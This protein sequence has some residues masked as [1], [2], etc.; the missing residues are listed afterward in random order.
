MTKRRR[1]AGELDG[2]YV[3]QS[4]LE[5]RAGITSRDLQA[6]KISK[7]EY[8]YSV[9][10]ILVFLFDQYKM[11]RKM[12]GGKPVGGVDDG[13]ADLVALDISKKKEE[14]LARQIK[15]QLALGDLIL[16]AEAQTR[17]LALLKSYQEL[18]EKLLHGLSTAELPEDNRERLEFM[19]K[20]F[21]G[22]V[23]RVREDGLEIL[24]W[25]RDGKARLLATRIVDMNDKEEQEQ[26]V[27]NYLEDFLPPTE[28]DF[29]S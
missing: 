15:N 23:T 4:E 27:Q 6:F 21:N 5:A 3:S 20:Y 13:S 10:K 16:K 18:L 14:V 28:E 29:L 17:M 19:T 8:G 2:L 22:L 12:A 24:S 11:V 9:Y 25:E 7:D 1:Y 26:E